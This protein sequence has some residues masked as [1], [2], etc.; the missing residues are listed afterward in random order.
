MLL[1]N[2][3]FVREI[4]AF[5]R[6]GFALLAWPL[7]V[8]AV[9]LALPLLLMERA[10]SGRL[11]PP[12]AWRGLALVFF[13][14]GHAA[15]CGGVGWIVGKRVF[16]E[17][18]RRRSLDGL[19][20]LTTPPA[21]WLAQKLVFPIYL[22]GL[23]W[24]A[25]LPFYA[26]G[27]LRAHFLPSQLV[28]GAQLALALG[29]LTFGAA[30]LAPAEGL[31]S[32]VRGGARVRR[33]AVWSDTLLMGLPLW[34][35]LV[36]LRLALDWM[37]YALGQRPTP[38]ANAPFFGTY[39]ST[40]RG[41]L[42]LLAVYAVACYGAAYPN[43][44]PAGRWSLP[45]RDGSRVF[46]V[47][48]AY[49]LFLGYSWRGSLDL[50]FLLLAALGL[51]AAVT[52]SLPAEWRE[53]LTPERGH[54]PRGQDP[55]AARDLARLGRLLDNAVFI[56]DLRVALR[57][58]GLGRQFLLHG[59]GLC[60]LSG[61]VGSLGLPFYGLPGRGSAGLP[62]FAYQWATGTLLLG[63]WLI[64]PAL[65]A[66]GGRAIA[67]WGTERRC[68][69]LPQIFATPLPTEA[70]VRGR[71]LAAVLI[72]VVRAVPVP[73]GFLL[74]LLL[75]AERAELPVYV[76]QGVWLA[77]LGLI[78]SAGLAGSA[79]DTSIQLEDLFC[80]G[81]LAVYAVMVEGALFLWQWAQAPVTPSGVADRS[82]LVVYAW[83]MVPLNL[84]LTW[85]VYRRAV[86]DIAFLRRKESEYE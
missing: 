16:G 64:L 63:S 57:G 13:G 22:L 56:R 49:L 86:A 8:Q 52:V 55:H 7:L 48:V 75:V 72:G 29:L 37:Y 23:V 5:G 42:I 59:A 34:I 25:G 33:A 74:A 70:F 15:T 31:R 40:D 3:F 39:L 76:A 2:P 77:S 46:A 54:R 43:A 30:L 61:V 71:W 10:T 73:L 27:A 44:H 38:Y 60:A 81:C 9:F 82:G 21:V 18:H 41:L 28:P 11:Q 62:P 20:L 14:L 6:R 4:R 79:Q 84:L 85:G 24:A 51:L 78:L 47:G 19:R 66:Y 58:A 69:M 12:E 35:T 50:T 36:L 32:P 53:R 80:S 45:L 67:N 17:E 65:L 26:A 1:E 68:A 83:S